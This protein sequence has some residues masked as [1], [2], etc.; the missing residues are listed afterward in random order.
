MKN[1]PD[2]FIWGTAT[3]AYQIEGASREDGRG[4]S[5]WDRFCHTH[6]N[7]HNQD[8]G[9]RACEHYYRLEEDLNILEDLGVNAYR[10]SV[11]WPRIQ[12]V[13]RGHVN[14]RGIDFYQRLVDGLLSRNITPTATLYHWDLP[15]ALQLEGGWNSRNTASYF[16]E[17]AD[18]VFRSL[19]DRVHSWITINEPWVASFMGHWTGQHAPGLQNFQI[20]LNVAHHL[21]LAHG[22]AVE[23]FRSGNHKGDIGITCD[24]SSYYPVSESI[25][26]REAALRLDEHKVK[27]FTHPVLKGQYPEGLL[28]WYSEKGYEPPVQDGDMELISGKVD[29]LGI[30]YYSSFDI[31]KGE[32]QP[33]EADFVPT[34]RDKTAMGWEI[35]PEGLYDL[36]ISLQ[37][38]FPETPFLIT[39]N[40]AACN[41]EVDEDGRVRDN[42]RID[43]LKSHFEMALKAI[44]DGV[45][46]KG[47]FIWSLMDNFEWAYGYEK[48]FGIIHVDFSNLKRTWK[49]S[50]AW[51]YQVFESGHTD[52]SLDFDSF[53]DEEDE[54]D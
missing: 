51:C 17:Y 23:V 44:E 46:L 19:G 18:E 11:S 38:Q 3:S 42:E 21:L 12:P 4:D 5:I 39:E 28:S 6:G 31:K 15:V 16:A 43:Y 36:L 33:L 50:A 27:W 8:T 52:V 2:D 20:A 32:N 35:R 37:K 13:G 53:F 45:P 9:D 41:D 10:F 14:G 54:D 26:D 24:M 40:G 34:G 1:F 25:E 30:N 22:K 7:I 47:Y 29:F 48:R 49:D